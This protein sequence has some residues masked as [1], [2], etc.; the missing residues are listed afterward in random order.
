VKNREEVSPSPD[1]NGCNSHDR[2][3][4]RAL[5]KDTTGRVSSRDDSR[6]EKQRR[7]SD[8]AAENQHP[9]QSQSILSSSSRV[10]HE[11]ERVGQGNLVFNGGAVVLHRRHHLLAPAA[12]VAMLPL[13]RALLPSAPTTLAP[14]HLSLTRT[15]TTQIGIL[16]W[17]RWSFAAVEG[18]QERSLHGRAV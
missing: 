9:A 2:P 18:N 12:A 4:P 6:T 15:C 8:G 17:G 10:R 5:G 14:T 11:K 16:V 1:M 13:H 3:Q 7:Q